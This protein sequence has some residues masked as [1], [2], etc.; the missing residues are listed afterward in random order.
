MKILCISDHVRSGINDFRERIKVI[1]N[2][3]FTVGRLN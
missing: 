2:T 1:T 3:S